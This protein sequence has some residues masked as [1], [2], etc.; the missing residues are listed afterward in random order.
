MKE[1]DLRVVKTKRAIQTAVMEL[2]SQKEL[3]RVTISEV[4]A[5]AG[6]N[7][8]TFYRHYRAVDDV[9]AELESEILSQFSESVKSGIF[10]LGAVIREISAVISRRREYF[11]RL[12][13]HNPD[14]FANGKIKAI[15]CRMVAVALKNVG[16]LEDEATVTAAAEFSVSGVLALYFAWFDGGCEGDLEFLTDVAVKMVTREL[17]AF[18][19]EDKLSEMRLK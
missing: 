2:L 10:D 11:T 19:S 5:I 14:L 1:S 15:L 8:K 18:V 12:L 7:R 6:I 9:I 3:P 17:A 4:C 16:A 13:K